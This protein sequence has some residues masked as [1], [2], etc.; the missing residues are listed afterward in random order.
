MTLRALQAPLDGSAAAQNGKVVTCAAVRLIRRGDTIA[1]SGFVGVGF[2][3][4]LA[5]ALEQFFLHP[6]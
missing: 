3:E 2:P 4:S 1:T 6:Q 5:I